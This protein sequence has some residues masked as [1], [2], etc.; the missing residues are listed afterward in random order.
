MTGRTKTRIGLLLVLVFAGRP[1]HGE[2]EPQS[3][4]PA[5]TEEER[6]RIEDVGARMRALVEA[7]KAPSVAA[8]VARGGRVVWERAWGLA[9]RE[10]NRAATPETMYFTASVAK[11]L[12]ATAAL[13]LVERGRIGL[14]EPARKWLPP[15]L[16]AVEPGDARALTVRAL[17]DM[18]AGI[19]HMY[20]FYWTD[21]TRPVPTMAEVLRAHGFAAFKPGR[22]F[23]YSNLSFGVVEEIVARAAGREFPRVVA[24]ELLTPLRLRRTALRPDPSHRPF[25]SAG[26][27]SAG[28]RL[29][30]D[31]MQPD[32]GAGFWSSVHDLALFG[33]SFASTRVA[34]ARYALS[35]ETCALLKRA[36]GFYTLGWWRGFGAEEGDVLIADGSAAPGSASLQVRPA[37]GVAAAVA[38]NTP[39]GDSETLLFTTELL[40]AL[41]GVAAPQGRFDLPEAL[42]TRDWKT[43]APWLGW[44]RGVVRTPERSV[45]LE[46]EFREDGTVTGSL[47]GREAARLS[48][49]REDGA[50]FWGDL[51]SGLET[52]ETRAAPHKVGLRL[53]LEDD[54]T[55]R[56][57]V[58]AMSTGS[59]ARFGL[60]FAAVLRPA[61]RP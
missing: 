27:S 33:L 10:G 13:R 11:S 43:P 4:S 30:F 6:R 46:L 16:L 12:T 61:R 15:D 21:E 53:R 45:A 42:R 1:V 31:T 7:G 37:D 28:V 55:L 20:A 60:P 50:E 18:T 8:A 39:A 51:P 44:W 23:H 52:A 14:D 56:G 19:P 32:G 24:D 29:A 59:R 26:Y 40:A 49:V 38:M 17:L 41:R 36:R 5:L 54:G 22:R 34:S 57:Y 25:L 2:D 48:S 35:P 47:D 9:D 3:S 58:L